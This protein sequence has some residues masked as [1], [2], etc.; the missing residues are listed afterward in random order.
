MVACRVAHRL[1]HSSPCHRVHPLG[2]L[3]RN[4]EITSHPSGIRLNVVV[5]S[6]IIIRFACP[7]SL[8]VL[9]RYLTSQSALALTS[10]ALSLS[11]GDQKVERRLA[12]WALY[13]L[14]AG[15]LDAA[16][17]FYFH[18]RRY[19]KKIHCVVRVHSF[20]TASPEKKP[21]A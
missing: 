15:V 12:A 20:S 2:C 3:S 19:S 10:L 4:D 17:G 13:F 7:V 1:S 14:E 21:P 11:V 6:G 8:Q 5:G 9:A 18:V 16:Y